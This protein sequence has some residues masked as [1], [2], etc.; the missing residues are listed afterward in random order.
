MRRPG[1][2]I[3]LP[4]A[5]ALRHEK[6]RLSRR[7]ETKADFHCDLA[8]VPQRLRLGRPVFFL[9]GPLSTRSAM[10]G[11]YYVYILVSEADGRLH[12][13]G[14]TRDLNTRLAEHNRGKSEGNALTPRNTGHGKSKQ[15]SH[16][17]RKLK[18]AVLNVI[19]RQDLDV[20]LR[21]AT[22]DS[23]R[24]RRSADL[25]KRTRSFHRATGTRRATTLKEVSVRP[26]SWPSKE[27]VTDPLR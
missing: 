13:S 15:Q 5:Y 9:R 24:V 8:S 2:R 1:V 14:L 4:P 20:N 10:K 26:Q 27:K 6:R 11:F 25:A 17:D 16:F 19:L 23:F 18:L 12:Y 21:A 3:P 22:Y 7:S